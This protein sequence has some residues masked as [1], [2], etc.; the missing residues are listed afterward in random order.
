MVYFPALG[1]GFL[2]IEIYLIEKASLLAGRPHQRLRPGADRDAD[3]LRPR[4]PAGRPVR[5]QRRIAR[6]ALARRRDR[7]G[8]VRR[9]AGRAAAADPGDARW[10]WLARAALVLRSL[11]P[12]SLALGLPF[13]LGL[14][15]RRAAARFLPWAWALNGAFSVVATPLA[16][17]IAREAGFSRVLLCAAMLYVRCAIDIS[18]RRGRAAVAP[19]YPARSHAAD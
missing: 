6:I 1:L 4:Q 10:P 2:F 16:N 9:G 14:G 19:A 5:R 8:L 15:P 17:L 11:A 13:P 12:V 18:Q 7:A 3:L